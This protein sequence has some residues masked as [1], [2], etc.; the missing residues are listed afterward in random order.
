MSEP[1]QWVYVAGK[2]CAY[3]KDGLCRRI[4]QLLEEKLAENIKEAAKLLEK[5]GNKVL[6][7]STIRKIYYEYV[8]PNSDTSP[9]SGGYKLSI[10]DD[11]MTPAKYI[12]AA[13][14]VLGEIDLDPASKEVKLW[15]S[16]RNI[17]VS[18]PWRARRGPA[19]E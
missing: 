1:I 12:E 6:K 10:R 17:P 7:S 3:C 13:R 5:E 14:E 2:E 19:T 8:L 16:Q 18:S 4:D 11:W 15:P 9:E